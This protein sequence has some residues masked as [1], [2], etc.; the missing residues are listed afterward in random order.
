MLL[1][2]SS[3][4]GL[5][6]PAASRPMPSTRTAVLGFVRNM[7]ET[8]PSLGTAVFVEATLRICCEGSRHARRDVIVAITLRVMSPEK[9]WARHAE[10]D[11]YSRN[12]LSEERDLPAGKTAH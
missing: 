2:R 11:G 1:G 8:P 6:T 3:A 5:A 7:A 4:A 12:C 10:R 9:P